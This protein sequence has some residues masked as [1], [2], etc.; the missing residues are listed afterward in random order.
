MSTLPAIMRAPMRAASSKNTSTDCAC[1][2]QWDHRGRRARPHAF[3]QE[4]LRDIARVRGIGEL[5]LRGERV[6]FEPVDEL[7]AGRGDHLRLRVMHMRIDE[8]GQDQ[9]VPV[10]RH[11]RVRRKRALRRLV[12]A[13]HRDPPVLHDEKRVA[14]DAYRCRAAHFERVAVN[15]SAQPRIAD[16][17]AMPS[18]DD[19]ARVYGH[20][21]RN[22][23]I[24]TDLRDGLKESVSGVRFRNQFSTSREPYS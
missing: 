21:R 15:V 5:L 18:P 12:V 24:V 20:S 2:V 14:L 7:P 19:H 9:R 16:A 11:L 3:A 4:H 10:G 8:T 23:A 6:V 17:D 1:T 22:R 13:E